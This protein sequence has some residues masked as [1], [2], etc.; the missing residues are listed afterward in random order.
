MKLVTPLKLAYQMSKE[1]APGRCNIGSRGRATRL[2]T[3][4]AV[5]VVCIILAVTLLSSMELRLARLL[6]AL[7]LYAGF[8]AALEGSMS[9][10]VFQ[11]SRG[12]YDFS[13]KFGPFGKSDT[14]RVVE[15]QEWRQM[16]QRKAR[17]MHLEAAIGALAVAALLVLV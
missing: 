15:T 8:L 5:V 10:C 11:A 3:G 2:S 14:R 1:Y 13:E 7:P 6:L 16:D 17:K 12:T 4:A 9:F